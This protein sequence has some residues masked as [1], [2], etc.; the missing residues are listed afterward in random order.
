MQL[1]TY[2]GQWLPRT[3]KQ[4]TWVKWADTTRK[5]SVCEPLP[6]LHTNYLFFVPLGLLFLFMKAQT[7]MD[8]DWLIWWLCTII[9]IPWQIWIIWKTFSTS[10]WGNFLT[11]S[12]MSRLFYLCYTF[13]NCTFCDHT[14]RW[15][16]KNKDLAPFPYNALGLPERLSFWLA[17]TVSWKQFANLFCLVCTQSFKCGVLFGLLWCK[18]YAKLWCD[19]KKSLST[20]P[21]NQEG[22]SS[23]I[24]S[25]ITSFILHRNLHP[26]AWSYSL[27]GWVSPLCC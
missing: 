17:E 16:L 24:A 10:V 21:H 9:I 23:L 22:S 6:R 14:L 15:T 1:H 19:S 4:Q 5:H 25:R 2:I 7:M 12:M 20:P 3:D 26:C 8:N 13:S 18:I 11:N 27:T